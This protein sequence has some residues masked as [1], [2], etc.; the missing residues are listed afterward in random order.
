[1][2]IIKSALYI[3]FDNMAIPLEMNG[4]IT[5]VMTQLDS[6]LQYL[7]TAGISDT[8][9]GNLNLKRIFSKKIV[10]YNPRSFGKYELTF[11]ELGFITVPCPVVTTLNKTSTDM[12]LA[13]EMMKDVTRNIYEDFILVS[14]DVDFAPVL[15]HINGEGKRTVQLGLSPQNQIIQGAAT[16][17]L[18]YKEVISIFKTP[19]DVFD[20]SRDINPNPTVKTVQL[21]VGVVSKNITEIELDKAQPPVI[22]SHEDEDQPSF[23]KAKI[24][25]R[26]NKEGSASQE[27]GFFQK[28]SSSSVGVKNDILDEFQINN[29]NEIIETYF[30][31]PILSPEIQK[32]IL[33]VYSGCKNN[34]IQKR[35]INNTVLLRLQHSFRKDLKKGSV[36]YNKILD[37][38]RFITTW[39]GT[40][41]KVPTPENIL[42]EVIRNY[43]SSEEF[44]KISVQYQ[45]T[46]TDIKRIFKEV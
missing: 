14:A 10:F 6:L 43:L 1:M 21:P 5:T 24:I 7:T 38:L 33:V 36:E 29:V 18:E 23:K 45:I 44:K 37:Y 17:S 39:F 15:L 3:D 16:I 12:W 41:P 46:D 31:I 40:S 30:G 32:E 42:S 27:A 11:K 25:S 19:S 26:P 13:V 20:A 35:F 2:N 8:I 34:G 22:Q 28:T 4:K 9:Y